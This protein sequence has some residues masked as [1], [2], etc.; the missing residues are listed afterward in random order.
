MNKIIRK[1][2]IT[3]FIIVQLVLT[4]I[5]FI[6]D[7]N[8]YFETTYIK[9]SGIILC[10]IASILSYKSKNKIL[11]IGALAITLIADFFLLVLNK[12]YLI[13]IIAFIFVQFLYFLFIKPKNIVI[14]ISVRLGLFLIVLFVVLFG[15]NTSDLTVIVAI[16]YFV[17]LIMN[18][19]DSWIKCKE[20]LLLFAIG[21]TLFIGCDISVGLHNL[22]SYLTINSL[23]IN[24][25]IKISHLGM[26]LFYLP[27]QALIVLSLYI[28]LPNKESI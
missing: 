19:V 14:S 16:F 2:P 22:S 7:K 18:A 6:A 26:W 17:N 25:L 23:F 12:Y 4:I 5:I 9:Y 20:G 1:S 13:G 24:E 21:L 28:E 8:D 15:F 10:F 11:V 3:C 27:S